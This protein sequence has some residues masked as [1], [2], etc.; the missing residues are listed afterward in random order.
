MQCDVIHNT[1]LTLSPCDRSLFRNRFHDP[2]KLIV[3]NGYHRRAQPRFARYLSHPQFAILRANSKNYRNYNNYNLATQDVEKTKYTLLDT[4]FSPSK[5]I[6]NK[7]LNLKRSSRLLLLSLILSLFTA[8]ANAQT[9]V[10][11]D[12]LAEAR[13]KFAQTGLE[14][15]DCDPIGDGRW[16]CSDENVPSNYTP[17]SPTPTA[18]SPATDTDTDTD[19]GTDTGDSSSDV[20][21]TSGG[22]TIVVGNSISDAKAK[23]AQTGL[24]RK[25]CDPIGGGRWACSDENVPANFTPPTSTPTDTGSDIEPVADTG[26]DVDTGAGTDDDNDADTDDGKITSGIVITSGATRAEA[27]AKYEALTDLPMVECDYQAPYGFVCGNINN[28]RII[29]GDTTPTVPTT[30]TAPTTPVV[31][32][33]TP[34]PTLP[35]NDDPAPAVGLANL[36]QIPATLDNTYKYNSNSTSSLVTFRDNNGNLRQLYSFVRH[37]D[38]QMYLTIRDFPAGDWE[39]PV[40]VHT[41]AMGNSQWAD[42][43]HNYTAVGVAGDGTIFVTGNHHSNNLR[44]A[45]SNQPYSISNGFSNVNRNNIPGNYTGRVTYPSFSYANGFL[46]FSYRDQIVGQGNSRFRWVITRYNHNSNTFDNLTQLNSGSALRL[47]LSNVASSPDGTTLHW[48][49]IW[50]D[51]NGSGSGTEN[52]AD[53]FHFFSRNGGQSWTQYGL[54]G[55]HR[56][57]LIWNERGHNYLGGADNPAG[58]NVQQ[59]IWNTPSNPIP[60]NPGSIA[61]DSN[62]NPHILNDERGGALWYHRYTGAQ[63]MSVKPPFQSSTDAPFSMGNGKMGAL[64]HRGSDIYFHSLDPSDR[65]YSNGVLLARGYANSENN[66]VADIVAVQNGW[67]ST[68]IMQANSHA[69]RSNVPA[70]PQPAFILSVPIDELENFDTPFIR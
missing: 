60:N 9:I 57:P 26:T 70:N 28:P 67:L 20:I 44:M 47:Y 49:G 22:A 32:E 58:F 23:F 12:S 4:Y 54:S 35:V 36:K 29:S 63:W 68:A 2:E 19:T 51:D 39:N 69:P 33:P 43:N 5:K 38:R 46:Y 40:N 48:S 66:A 62:G 1:Q 61:V 6:E 21:I 8:V 30:P 15:K 34:E 13:E 16:A 45:K 24:Q 42:D 59:L 11:G 31:V 14:R 56:F 27:V 53:L 18:P 3:L 17:P 55:N 7:Q 41:A 65:S 25:D 50:R 37:P 52:Q 10:V 64:V